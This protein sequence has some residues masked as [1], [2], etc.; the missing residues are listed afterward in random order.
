MVRVLVR[1]ALTA[2]AEGR[3]RDGFP[4]RPP[5]LWGRSDGR[6]PRL[7]GRTVRHTVGGDEPI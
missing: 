1:R 3:E 2:L 6:F 5:L 7:A 4:A